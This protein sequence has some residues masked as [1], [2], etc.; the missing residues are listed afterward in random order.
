MILD[1]LVMLVV[2]GLSLQVYRQS[3]KIKK[4]SI[5][6][7]EYTD[8]QVTELSN[9]VESRLRTIKNNLTALNTI[10]EIING[11]GKGSKAK[12]GRAGTRANKATPGIGKTNRH[13]K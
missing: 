2:V 11:Q 9:A 13:K 1:I 8:M 4:N 7:F 5:D 3:E 10:A 12:A 6:N